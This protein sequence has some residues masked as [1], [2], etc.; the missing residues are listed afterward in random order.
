MVNLVEQMLAAK[1]QLG[2]ARSDKD[3]SF[4]ENKC[5]ALDRQIDRLVFELYDLTAEEIALVENAV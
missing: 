2:E 4:C 5:R 1:R 3:R